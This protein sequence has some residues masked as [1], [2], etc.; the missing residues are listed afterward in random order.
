MSV[1][2]QSIDLL[3]AE[4]PTLRKRKLQQGP[5]TSDELYK[6]LKRENIEPWSDFTY[7]NICAA[8]A[9]NLEDLQDLTADV[10]Q[11]R[12][13]SPFEILEEACV[14]RVLGIWNSQICRKPLKR[15]AANLQH[16][17]ALTSANITLR[18]HQKRLRE[19][20]TSWK[21]RRPD[22]AIFL[23][24]EATDEQS[25]LVWGEN[26]L[27]SKWCS[28]I[29]L[30]P[31]SLQSNWIWPFRQVLT[32]CVASNTRY[33]CLM[34]DNELVVLRIYLNDNSSDRAWNMQ[35]KSIPWENC[36][37]GNLTVNLGI[38]AIG[39]M[40]LNEGHR[41]ISPIT[42]T[43]P[44]NVW[45]KDEDST[46]RRFYEHHLSSY[47]RY[48]RPQGADARSRPDTLPSVPRAHAERSKRVRRM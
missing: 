12:D 39:V 41:P 4:N 5:V 36:G 1:R 17:L 42:E 18:I 47:K 25:T 3:T 34:T 11:E 15:A 19:N 38:W 29:S 14:D 7:E 26:K 20:D 31:E 35:Y 28:D 8:Y 45:W 40:A 13:G 10:F 46:G 30:L 33:G 21:L 44:L 43:L 32:Y 9:P 24:D 2:G 23:N 16:D 48:D 22:W 37:K 27:S 6:P